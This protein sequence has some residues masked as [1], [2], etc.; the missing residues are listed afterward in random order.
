MRIHRF[1]S[2]TDLVVA[3]VVAVAI[4]LPKRPIY[5]VDAYT[6]IDADA[7]AD[8]AGAE[9]LALARP[10]DGAAQ[11]A[12]A[13]RLARAEQL[14]WAVEVAREGADRA[15]PETRWRALFAAAE[16]YADRIQVR[17]AA[18]WTQRA[19]EACAE[20]RGGCPPWEELK[21]RLYGQYLQA[22]V[23]SG[24]DPRKH[25][26]AF[27]EAANQGMHTVDIRG[28]TPGVPDRAPTPPTGDAAP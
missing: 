8:L 14:D 10:D 19:L 20:A 28:V 1:L 4:F 23:A 2:L 7:R 16:A 6:K 9:G 17:D 3:V 11:A 18:D 22:G 21:M 27:R 13:R 12:F 5:A 25:P 24:I 15:T 26:R